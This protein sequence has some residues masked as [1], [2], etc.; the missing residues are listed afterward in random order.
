MYLELSFRSSEEEAEGLGTDRNGPDVIVKIA[1]VWFEGPDDLHIQFPE[2]GTD[3]P[4]G[5][6]F[7][8]Q[9]GDDGDYIAPHP[10]TGKAARVYH[11]GIRTRL[12]GEKVTKGYAE[13]LQKFWPSPNREALK[14]TYRADGEYTKLRIKK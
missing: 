5:D 11:F 4:G 8:P 3:A 2:D 9:E 6:N 1:Y 14:T 10:E 13:L 7:C 12:D